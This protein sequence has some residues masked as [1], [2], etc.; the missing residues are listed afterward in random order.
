MLK[1]AII[2]LLIGLSIFTVV[3]FISSQTRLFLGIER[4]LINGLFFMREPEIHEPNPLVSREVILLGFD[5]DSIASI[6][7][8]PWKRDVH[9]Q[10]L[11]NL[12]KFSPRTVMFDVVFVKSETIP[13]F[14]SEKLKPEPE[15]LQK[16]E[17]AFGEMDKAFSKTLE[18]YHNVFLM[19]SWWN[20]PER[21]FP[22]PT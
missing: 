2:V 3:H 19:F 1:K 11:E 15:L 5:E 18:K 22:K 4:N 7:K 14:L 20:T 13:P 16:V 10:M 21:I 9:A 6:G 17:N 8:W 12:E